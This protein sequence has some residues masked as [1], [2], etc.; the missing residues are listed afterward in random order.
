M[1]KINLL[2]YEIVDSLVSA[3]FNCHRHFSAAMPLTFLRLVQ[4]LFK[5]VQ[6]IL[7]VS[8]TINCHWKMPSDS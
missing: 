1:K 3:A 6:P 4:L 5:S 2:T 7:K 8:A